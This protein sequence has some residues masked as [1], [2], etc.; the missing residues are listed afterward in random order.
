MVK[1]ILTDVVCY[2]IRKKQGDRNPKVICRYLKMRY[3]ITCSESVVARRYESEE[4]LL[5]SE[6][7]I[8]QDSNN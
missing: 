8:S 4:C 1:D 5:N 3:G 6:S 2:Y 7:N